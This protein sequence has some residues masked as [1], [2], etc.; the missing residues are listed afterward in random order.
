[1]TGR[2]QEAA[3]SWWWCFLERLHHTKECRPILDFSPQSCFSGPHRASPHTDNGATIPQLTQ[4]KGMSLSRST[5]ESTHIYLSHG[6]GL[7]W[8][9]Q[10]QGHRI[11][12]GH[13][14]KH[15]LSY[16]LCTDPKQNVYCAAFLFFY[17]LIVSEPEVTDIY[18]QGGIYVVRSH[19]N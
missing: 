5:V 6:R 3:E 14:I 19:V 4:D 15:F 2:G 8:P 12:T 11:I 10:D 7:W 18:T 13:H 9:T 17:C 1:M 16:Y